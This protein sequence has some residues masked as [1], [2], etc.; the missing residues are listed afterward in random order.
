VGALGS[1]R[2]LATLTDRSPSATVFRRL[3]S[4]VEHNRP[5]VS[6]LPFPHAWAMILIKDFRLGKAYPS[7]AWN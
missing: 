5:A 3:V 2:F 6:A 4:A 7:N 1:R